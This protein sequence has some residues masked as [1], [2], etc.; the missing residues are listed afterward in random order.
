M[1]KRHKSHE[2]NGATPFE[3]GEEMLE[4]TFIID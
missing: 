3:G 1:S 2:A 4:D